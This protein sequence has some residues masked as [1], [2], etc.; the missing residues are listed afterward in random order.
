MDTVAAPAACAAP[1]DLFDAEH[2]ALLAAR[3]A[4]ELG[5]EAG[6]RACHQ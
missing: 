6:A 5:E 2:R 3:A 1:A 4:H